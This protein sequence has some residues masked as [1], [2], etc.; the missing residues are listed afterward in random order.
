MNNYIFILQIYK[1]KIISYARVSFKNETERTLK[2]RHTY[3]IRK[4]KTFFSYEYIKYF[5][6]SLI[7]IIM[8]DTLC[9]VY[10]FVLAPAL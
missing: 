1:K 6:V 2:K 10:A 4:E 3:M 7:I 9:R 5:F 8:L